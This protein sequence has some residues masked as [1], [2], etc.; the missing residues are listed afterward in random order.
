M[1]SLRYVC[2]SKS[3]YYLCTFAVSIVWTLN[4][5]Y[6][7]FYK[8]LL[9]LCLLSLSLVKPM[10]LDIQFLKFWYV[11]SVCAH[12][13][14]SILLLC[15]FSPTALLCY[16][17][18]STLTSGQYLMPTVQTCLRLLQYMSTYIDCVT[19]LQY[20]SYTKLYFWYIP[21]MIILKLMCYVVE[22]YL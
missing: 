4:V 20:G 11:I 5:M 14:A 8:I 12:I 13:H 21:L 19:V 22:L 9:M 18:G 17:R 7:S 6:S 10:T 2:V 1:R 16:Q 15:V 3:T